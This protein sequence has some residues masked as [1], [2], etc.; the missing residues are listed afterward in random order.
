MQNFSFHAN[1]FTSLNGGNFYEDSTPDV[2]GR[3]PLL[4]ACCFWLCWANRLY[5]RCIT[6]TTATGRNVIDDNKPYNHDHTDDH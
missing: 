1:F 6:T 5:G 2:R 4:G 3:D